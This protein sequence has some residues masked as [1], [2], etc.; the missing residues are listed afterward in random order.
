M[1]NQI[2]AHMSKVYHVCPHMPQSDG[3]QDGVR[4]YTINP[5]WHP[6]GGQVGTKL[7]TIDTN[8]M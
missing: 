2:R 3:E 7:G 8:Q 1:N 5:I 4:G 6:R